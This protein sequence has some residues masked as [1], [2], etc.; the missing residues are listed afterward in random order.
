MATKV[1]DVMTRNVD[2]ARPE[3]PVDEIA[4]RM[5]RGGF[6]FMPVVEGRKLIGA[7]T[8]RDL[9]V[10]VLAA[11]LDAST[12]VGEVLTRE[13]SFVRPDE[14]IGDALAKLGDEQLHRLPVLDDMDE[15]VGVVT[16][17]DLTSEVRARTAGEALKDISAP[18]GS[19]TFS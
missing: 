6:G 4:R 13:V 8:D 15:L 11:G 10:R 16:L 17:G 5:A 3:Q 19:R 1:Q 14:D 12:P 7:I 2:V 9:A 18:E